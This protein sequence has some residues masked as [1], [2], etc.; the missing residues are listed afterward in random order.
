MF[1]NV[2]H[3]LSPLELEEIKQRIKSNMDILTGGCPDKQII[4]CLMMPTLLDI[5]KDFE[6]LKAYNV[7]EISLTSLDI[8]ISDTLYFKPRNARY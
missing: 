3:T 4:I 5:T 6:K 2:K 8:E 7:K 1:G